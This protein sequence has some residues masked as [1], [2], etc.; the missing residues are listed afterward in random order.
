MAAAVSGQQFDMAAMMGGPRGLFE[1][2]VPSFLFLLVFTATRNMTWALGLAIGATVIALISR[3][4]SRSTIM[5]GIVGVIG[6]LICAWSARN[7]GEARDFFL[8][9]FFVNIGY[10]LV[11]LISAL[12]TPKIGKLA[13]GPWPIVGI[14]VG[15]F[16]GEQFAWRNNP[17]RARAFQLA[18]LT[19]AGMFFSRLLVQVPLYIQDNVTAL[20]TARLIMST[21]MA[22]LAGWATFMLLK[23]APRTDT[24]GTDEPTDD[25][26]LTDSAE[27]VGDPTVV[28]RPETS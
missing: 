2:V 3:L 21:P 9:G 16:T 11:F 6:V 12:P 26:D 25:P 18:T 27:P 13:K 19:F 28:D 20:G 7:S 23:R 1:G 17:A 22:L 4:I 10:G 15:F 8:P 14:A 5:P 24:P